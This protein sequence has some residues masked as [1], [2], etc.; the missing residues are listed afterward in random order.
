[1]AYKDLPLSGSDYK[2][3]VAQ[4][5]FIALKNRFA[6]NN[7][8]LNDSQV[9]VI[10]RPTMRKFT[11]VG[12]GPVRKVYSA[13]GTF[14]NDLFAVSGLFLYRVKTDGTNELIGQLSENLLSGVA[15]A[16]TA[17]I[18]DVPSYLFIAE[19]RILWFFTDNGHAR[20]QLQ[21]TSTILN[22]DTIE[23]DGVYY[24]WTTGSVDAGTPDGTAGNPWLV[25]TDGLSNGVA[26]TNMFN[27][28]ND[29]GLGGTTYSTALVSHPTIES[30]SY[31]ANDLFVQAREAGVL[32]NGLTTTETAASLSWGAATLVN[33][34]ENQLSQVTLPD[35]IG[36]VSL[37]V[38]NSF[39]IVVP[40]QE[41]SIK[42][43]FYWIEPGET[44]VNP[45]NFATAERSP[46]KLLQVV[47]YGDMFWLF[48]ER[49]VEPWVTSGDPAAPM[50]RF[51]GILFDRGS[52]EG[53]AVQVKDSMIVVDEDGGV[54]RIS[55]GQKRISRPDI[56][57]RIRLS[58]QRQK[59]LTI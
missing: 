36:A 54:F 38:I 9:S 49:T 6:E 48:G 23:M 11:E 41:G 4:E 1:M 39:V 33:G 42:G 21:A 18:G 40:T 35:D 8:V 47:T 12:T 26:I 25:L 14:D 53:T 10:S 37:D 50:Q 44:V 55:G 22:G 45:L 20:G 15:M 59:A 46:D 57:E 27:A 28:I 7:P 58:L 43:R 24:Q 51:R 2:R 31:S 13:P 34:G 32:G 19:G 29:S 52:S 5:P 3:E 56:E 17:P 30:L 16:A